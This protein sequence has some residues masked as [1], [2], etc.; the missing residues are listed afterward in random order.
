MNC[1]KVKGILDKEVIVDLE[2]SLRAELSGH[3]TKCA[4]CAKRYRSAVALDASLSA[5][6]VEIDTFAL[7]GLWVSRRVGAGPRWILAAAALTIMALLGFYF[8]RAGADLPGPRAYANTAL[9]RPGEFVDGIQNPGFETGAI[10]ATGFEGSLGRWTLPE[11]PDGNQAQIDAQH[12]RFGGHALRLHQHEGG[13]RAQLDID[14]PIPKGTR[15]VLVAWVYSPWGGS[16]SNKWLAV[17]ASFLKRLPKSETTFLQST[18]LDFVV[19]TRDWYPIS[20][21][22]TAVS[23]TDGLR[24]EFDTTAGD[25]LYKGNDWAS[26]IDDVQIAVIVPTL[27]PSTVIHGDRVFVTFRLPKAYEHTPIHRESIF[28]EDRN[29][30]TYNPVPV[31][32]MR[33]HGAFVEL[34]FRSPEAVRSLGAGRPNDRTHVAEHRVRG[35][36]R[37]GELRVPFVAGVRG[38]ETPTSDLKP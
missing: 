25:G 8:G 4:A 33:R 11:L 27:D 38:H 15:V 22:L 21:N 17:G 28:L 19:P 36:L 12:G 20:L 2:P 13:D 5:A 1:R 32:D 9:P 35:K 7:A 16:A 14:L 3:F 34:E 24:F 10:G 29:Y 37:L 31:S 23:D 26:W 6:M 30:R 18:S